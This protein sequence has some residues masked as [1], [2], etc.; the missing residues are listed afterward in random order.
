MYSIDFVIGDGKK[1]SP[2]EVKS[3][4]YQTHASLDEFS[5]KYHSIIDKRYVVYNKNYKQAEGITYLPVY[6]VFML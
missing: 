4:K 2:I 6:M 1:I 5:K 3:S